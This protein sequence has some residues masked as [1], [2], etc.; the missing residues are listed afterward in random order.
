MKKLAVLLSVLSI[1]KDRFATQT[2]QDEISMGNNSFDFKLIPSMPDAVSL[3]RNQ[4][5]LQSILIA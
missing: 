5:V 3:T 2:L 4:K 1:V